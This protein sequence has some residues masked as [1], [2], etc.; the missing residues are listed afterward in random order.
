M[1]GDI[2]MLGP[3]FTLTDEDAALLVERTVR[4]VRSVG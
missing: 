4:A 2:V 3:P 1:A